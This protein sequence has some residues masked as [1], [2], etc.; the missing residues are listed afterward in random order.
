MMLIALLM[1]TNWFVLAS[2][3]CGAASEVFQ[4]G[5]LHPHQLRARLSC[6]SVASRVSSVNITWVADP[7]A[8][9][10]DG[11]PYG[12]YWQHATDPA[13]DDKWVFF[14]NGGGQCVD[15]AGCK[16][17]SQGQRG[18]LQSQECG[19]GGNCS[20]QDWDEFL[21]KMVTPFLSRS[22]SENGAMHT[23]NHVF[24]PFCS[25]DWWTGT[26]TSNNEWGMRFAGHV[27]MNAMVQ[28]LVSKGGLASAYTVVLA[29]SS[30]GGVG[31]YMHADWLQEQ[32]P[33][34]PRVVAMPIAG[35]FGVGYLYEGPN[36]I[37]LTLAPFSLE[38]TKSYVELWHSYLPQGCVAHYGEQG[39]ICLLS[40]FS[41]P[42]VKVPTFVVQAQSDC[43]QM[44]FNDGFPLPSLADSAYEHLMWASGY[45]PAS[46]VQFNQD[47]LAIMRSEYMLLN[48]THEYLT[49][50][51]HNQTGPLLASL[52][53]Q[54][55]IFNPACFI[56]IEFYV[57]SPLIGGQNFLH[58]FN[59]WMGG[60]ETRLTDDCGLLCGTLCPASAF[61]LPGHQ[62]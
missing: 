56:H 38:G 26:E 23:W 32:L 43:V 50:W 30:S 54:D 49:S 37:P 17:A 35:F 13:A 3:T 24:L 11:S 28:D 27:N 2:S 10:L 57:D 39:F 29:G 61:W 7:Q 59:K 1:S 8:A 44:M 6:R 60:T 45:P 42:F 48:E 5:Y 41:G 53:P 22:P 9:C 4:D 62:W 15:A 16:N 21:V 33:L 19:F 12:Y 18:S 36:A 58:A 14:M 52:K 51:K 20:S 34:V 25:Q 31:V 40:N 47:L 55:G 46:S